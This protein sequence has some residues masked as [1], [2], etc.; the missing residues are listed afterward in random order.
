MAGDANVAA[1]SSPDGSAVSGTDD[2]SGRVL[3]ASLLLVARWGIAKT[4]LA[5]VAREA[6]CSR[7]TVYRAFP[8][9]KAHLFHVL[10][11][12]ELASYLDAVLDAV[13]AGEDLVDAVTSGLVVATRLLQD[14]DAAQF[15]LDY[16]PGVLLPFLGF[17]QVDVLYSHAATVVGPHLERF[18]PAD[19][20]AWLSEWCARLFITYL[21][22]PD[23]E[24]DLAVEDQARHLVDRFVLPSFA[25]VSAH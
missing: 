24:I 23:P 16:E 12:R 11:V 13:D 14:H 22:N 25:P 10:A 19:R 3:D 9:G 1:A 7:A 17:K 15:V 21:F 6:R 8:G 18:L 4:A 5:D 20:A 2:L